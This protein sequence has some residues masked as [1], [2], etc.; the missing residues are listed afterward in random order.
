V[1]TP[2]MFISFTL[3]IPGSGGGG[4]AALR[5]WLTIISVDLVGFSLKLFC[6]TQEAMWSISEDIVLLL[7]D[8]TTKYV[9]SAYLCNLFPGVRAR[10]S[11][12]FSMK[13]IGPIA[14]PC[15]MLALIGRGA[16]ITPWTLVQWVRL[17][18]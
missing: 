2:K 10:R 1:V 11:V 3:V 6:L 17:H 7:L 8:G 14:E 4:R 13:A 5:P 9:S 12:G 15:T 18:R 16:D